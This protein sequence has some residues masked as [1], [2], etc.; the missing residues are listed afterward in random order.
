MTRA[1]QLAA[2][3]QQLAGI[4]AIFNPG[5]AAALS[6]LVGVGTQFFALLQQIK[7]DDPDMWAKVSEDY[8]AS[9]AGFEASVERQG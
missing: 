7:A 6:G 8:K 3:A 9:L 1:E 2:L 5:S 4:A